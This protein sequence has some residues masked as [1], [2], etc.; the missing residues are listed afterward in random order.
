MIKDKDKVENILYSLSVEPQNFVFQTEKRSYHS[1]ISEYLTIRSVTPPK[2]ILREILSGQKKVLM[3][4]TLLH[5]KIWELGFHNYGYLDLDS[6]IDTERRPI[7]YQPASTELNFKSSATLVG[8]YIHQ[9]LN[10]YPGLNTIVHVSYA[11]AD[12]LKPLFPGAMFNDPDT[13][14]ETL[15][16]FKERGGV[17]IAAGCSEGIDLP[18][19]L[20]RLIIIPILSRENVTD[21]VVVKRLA[22]HKGSQKY[23][24]NTISTLIQQAGR[25]TRGEE[26]YCL[27]VVGDRKLPML[28]VKNKA[29][30]PKSFYKAI[31]WS[32]GS[33]DK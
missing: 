20:C 23:D 21:P 25:G 2:A 13:K 14:N 32:H 5:H 29:M 8:N 30:V 33:T 6:P 4:A 9:V 24:L 1:T 31:K 19:N 16:R 26:D 3:S 7:A 28:M 10:T 17:W 18:G 22:M 11:W 27:T 15:A 12:K